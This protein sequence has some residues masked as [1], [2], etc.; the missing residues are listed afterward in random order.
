MAG[1]Y[2]SII[3]EEEPSGRSH[4]TSAG[5]RRTQCRCRLDASTAACQGQAEKACLC[6]VGSAFLWSRPH[7][8]TYANRRSKH[9]YLGGSAVGGSRASV[10]WQL[11]RG[12]MPSA[13]PPMSQRPLCTAMQTAPP[14]MQPRRPTRQPSWQAVSAFTGTKKAARPLGPGCRQ[15]CPSAWALVHRPYASADNRT[16]SMI[17]GIGAAH[18]G[19]PVVYYMGGL[20]QSVSQSSRDTRPETHQ[21]H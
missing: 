5:Q 8:A 21:Q 11:S 13:C 12:C 20:R 7:K 4:P 10:S 1:Y 9:L 16:D 15:R 14:S 18:T 2:D 17:I 6:W 19:A 3:E